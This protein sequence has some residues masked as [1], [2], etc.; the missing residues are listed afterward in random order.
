MSKTLEFRQAD[1]MRW[2]SVSVEWQPARMLTE[3]QSTVVLFLFGAVERY[4]IQ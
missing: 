4:D 1:C 3:L 2:L